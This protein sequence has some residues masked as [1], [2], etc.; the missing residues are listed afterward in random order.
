MLLTVALLVLYSAYAFLVGVVEDSW[1]LL[2][3][4]VGS[5]VAAYGTAMLRR[6]SQYLVYLLALGFIAKLGQSVYAGV[7]SGY[8]SLHFSS[9]AD[10]LM[11]LIPSA[12]MTALS[13]ACCLYVFR[14]FRQTRATGNDAGAA[15]GGRSG[16]QPSGPT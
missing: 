4:G 10:A 11:S 16:Q 7:V 15:K 6:W 5:I 8:F 9:T 13:V 14:Y 12:V 2:A 1:P 3:G